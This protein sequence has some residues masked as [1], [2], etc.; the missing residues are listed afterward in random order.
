ML[1][2]LPLGE[3]RPLVLEAEEPERE[4]LGLRELELLPLLVAA[5]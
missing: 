5:L 3:P 1:K 2:V 4:P